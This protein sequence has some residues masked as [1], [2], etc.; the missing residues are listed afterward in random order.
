M[1]TITKYLDEDGKEYS[2]ESDAVL[3]DR[4]ICLSDTLVSRLDSLQDNQ[5]REI[6]EWLIRNYDFKL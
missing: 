3:A 4:I 5:A 2:N 1:K 6:A